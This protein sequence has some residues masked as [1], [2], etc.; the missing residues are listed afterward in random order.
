MPDSH[1]ILLFMLAALMLNLTPG[2]DMLYVIARSVGQG[3]AAGVASAF[4]IAAGCCVHALA[5]A[6]GLV[7]LLTAFPAASRVL[8]LAGAGYL[9]YLG[10]RTWRSHGTPAAG[11]SLAPLAL[12]RVFLQGMLTNVLNPK[13]ALFFLAFLPQFVNQAAGN[14]AVQIL[15]LGAL[16]NCSG[17]L[18]NSAAAWL[19]SYT[20]ARLQAQL[21]SSDWFRWLSGGLLV[22]LGLR[23]A[24]L[25]R[26]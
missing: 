20:G 6:F 10:V 7:T 22:A 17:T 4:G 25:A 26:N 8:K 15:L 14:L 24:T 1:S 3:R 11:G 13:V 5:V 23:V 9:V 19:A 12:S 16:F 2:P 21:K 18:V